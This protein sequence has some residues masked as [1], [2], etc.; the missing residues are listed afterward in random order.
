MSKYN[1]L[2][3][4]TYTKITKRYTELERNLKEQQYKEMIT[5]IEDFNKEFPPNPKPSAE[6]LNFE[7]I[8][9][10]SKKQRE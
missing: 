5:Y 7:K 9:E 3:D 6:L 4:D 8:L 2:S 1:E 10:N